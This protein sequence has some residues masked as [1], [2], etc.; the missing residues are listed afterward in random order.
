MFYGAMAGANDVAMNAHGVADI[1]SDRFLPKIFG[2]YCV[3]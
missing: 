3:E 2:F 1:E